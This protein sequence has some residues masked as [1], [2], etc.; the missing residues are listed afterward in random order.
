MAIWNTILIVIMI[1][2]LMC[3]INVMCND[4]N[5]NNIQ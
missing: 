5:S 2:L 1:I 3:I 4:I